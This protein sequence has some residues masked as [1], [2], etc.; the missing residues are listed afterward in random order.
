MHRLLPYIWDMLVA[1]DLKQLRYFV[2]V[3]E[4]GHITRAAHA[5]G[6]QQPP[7]SQ[8][9]KALEASVGAQLL[10]RHPRGVSVTDSGKRLLDDA[11]RILADVAAVE[12]RFAQAASGLQGRLA[13]SFTS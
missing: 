13:I 1:M 6:M 11:R 5:L 4:A 2:A 3:A 9:M 8:Q 12:D 10:R 7:L